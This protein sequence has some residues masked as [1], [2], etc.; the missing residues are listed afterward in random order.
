MLVTL[1]PSTC[2]VTINITNVTEHDINL[3]EGM[4]VG[5]AHLPKEVLEIAPSASVTCGSVNVAQ[6]EPVTRLDF[7]DAPY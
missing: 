1:H 3:A 5:F 2:R 7:G 6:D 4:M